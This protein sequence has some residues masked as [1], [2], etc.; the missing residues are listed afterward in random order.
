MEKKPNPNYILAKKLLCCYISIR[1]KVV[2]KLYSLITKPFRVYYRV[3]QK[4]HHARVSKNTHPLLS[5]Y[6]LQ[7]LFITS[8]SHR[9]ILCAV[10]QMLYQIS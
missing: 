4:N 5:S 3:Q 1:R 9:L 10:L 6:S 2:K 8:S 7:Y